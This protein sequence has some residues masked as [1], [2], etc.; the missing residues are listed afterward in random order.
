M[1]KLLEK[2]ESLVEIKLIEVNKTKGIYA[3]SVNYDV[4]QSNDYSSQY[5]FSTGSDGSISDDT[6]IFLDTP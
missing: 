6:S 1:K 5:D 3:G 4:S 2:I